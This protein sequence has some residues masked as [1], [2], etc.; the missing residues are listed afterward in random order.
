MNKTAKK[1]SREFKNS[2]QS[3][4]A[5]AS[6][7]SAPMSRSKQKG[8]P[9]TSTPTE[10]VFDHETL[11]RKIKETAQAIDEYLARYPPDNESKTV[12]SATVPKTTQ[13]SSRDA[14]RPEQ[15][16][17]PGKSTSEATL[18]AAEPDPGPHQDVASPENP[19]ESAKSPGKRRI[20]QDQT[21][22]GQDETKNHDSDFF[23]A[24]F[25]AL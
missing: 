3:P 16:G 7:A 18:H 5:S 15:E 1:P 25:I 20:R 21:T 22:T 6:S 23:N 9:P 11:L 19:Q 4:K 8:S 12:P 10:P 17:F 13:S 2:H 14:V 24:D